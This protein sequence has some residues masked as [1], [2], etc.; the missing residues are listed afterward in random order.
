M[1]RARR[2]PLLPNSGVLRKTQKKEKT[3]N[4]RGTYYKARDAGMRPQ[5]SKHLYPTFVLLCAICFFLV[6]VPETAPCL[7]HPL[8]VLPSIFEEK[9]QTSRGSINKNHDSRKL[10]KVK[11]NQEKRSKMEPEIHRVLRLILHS[12]SALFCSCTSMLILAVKPSATTFHLPF[13]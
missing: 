5:F 7:I 9:K 6:G 1:H 4:C 2:N 8:I 3:P 12:H 10:F 11:D 13:S